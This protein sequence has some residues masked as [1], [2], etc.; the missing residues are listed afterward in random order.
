MKAA[1]LETSYRIVVTDVPDPEPQAGQVLVRVKVCGVASTDLKVF[2]GTNPWA[3]KAGDAR[4]GNAPNIIL[5]HEM[6]G[7]V[8]AVG[9]GAPERLLGRRVAVI[10]FHPCRECDL[11]TSGRP[12]LCRSMTYLGHNTG[13]PRRKFYPGGMAELCAVWAESCKEL[14][15]RVE[16]EDTVFLD[17]LATAIH[18]VNIAR[19]TKGSRILV[20]GCGPV[21]LCLTQLVEKLGVEQVFTSD[22][23][24]LTLE[25]AAGVSSTRCIRADMDDLTR[26]VRSETHAAGID[27][28]FDTVGIPETQRQARS[29]LAPGGSIV[30]MAMTDHELSFTL[31]DLGGERRIMSSLNYTTREFSQA[32]RALADG[33]VTVR[34]YIT[35]RMSLSEFPKVV[36]RLRV[37]KRH[38]ALKAV[39]LPDRS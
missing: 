15:R 8:E 35:H 38:G 12:N 4:H 39:V 7:V 23:Y 1:V 37:R 28:V 10:P 33:S 25:V 3:L 36:E 13:W 27:F 6:A 9:E 2:E 26:L 21:G 14:P 24:P 18:A 5:G 16:F 29:L 19:V 22:T 11:C 17:S 34:P 20:I 30:S 31:R 32:L